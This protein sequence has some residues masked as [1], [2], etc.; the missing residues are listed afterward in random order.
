MTEQ[1]YGKTSPKEGDV[2]AI[3]HVGGHTYIVKYGYYAEQDHQAE[4]EAGEYLVPVYPDF[5]SDPQYDE[6]GYS[7][8]TRIQAPCV[9]YRPSQPKAPEDWCRD[10][11]YYPS[12]K[13]PIG[14]CHCEGRRKTDLKREETK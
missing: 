14:I 10:C 13:A 6:K 9:F 1:R 2:Y 5:I 7:L 4:R 12:D 11:V 8:A 3:Y